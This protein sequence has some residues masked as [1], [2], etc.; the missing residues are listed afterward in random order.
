MPPAMYSLCTNCVRW[1][2]G[3]GGLS[4]NGDS[5]TDPKGAT[6]GAEI[7]VLQP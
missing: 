7:I 6:E 3:G 5:E 1:E 2:E 4:V